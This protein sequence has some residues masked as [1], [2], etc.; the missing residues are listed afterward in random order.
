MSGTE[1]NH[2]KINTLELYHNLAR[3]QLTELS[4]PGPFALLYST[5]T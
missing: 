4:P 3:T 5:H 1:T 2:R